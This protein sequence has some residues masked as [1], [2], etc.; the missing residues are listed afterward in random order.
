VALVEQASACLLL[1][2]ANTQTSNANRLKP[3][4]LALR[5]NFAVLL[6]P[7]WHLGKNLKIFVVRGISHD[8]RPDC[9]VEQASA[10]LLLNCANTQTSNA[11]RLKPVLLAFRSNF[12]VLIQPLDAYVVISKN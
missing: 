10:C 1:N 5:S 9:P 8:R 11:N 4:L 7:A 3:V 2:C 12:A 6:Q